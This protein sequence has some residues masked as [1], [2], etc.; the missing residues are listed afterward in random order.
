MKGKEVYHYDAERTECANAVR[1]FIEN[2]DKAYRILMNYYVSYRCMPDP[3]K[4]GNCHV[5]K[6]KADLLWNTMTLRS[7][8]PVI[9]MRS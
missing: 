6:T 5:T 7:S 2:N 1:E 3:F 8:L 4:S 9:M